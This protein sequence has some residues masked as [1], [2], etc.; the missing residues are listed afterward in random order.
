[1][2]RLSNYDDI[3]DVAD[4]DFSGISLGED[5][6]MLKVH[7]DI[8]FMTKFTKAGKLPAGFESWR[9]SW[10]TQGLAIEN[11]VI[12]EKFRPNWKFVGLRHGQSTAWVILQHPYGFTIEINP[13]A[14]EDIVGSLTM[15]NGVI[16]TPC[17][18]QAKSKN[19]ELLVRKDETH[20]Y[21]LSLVNAVS[22]DV[23][24]VT[25][26]REV[27]EDERPDKVYSVISST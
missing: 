22:D 11:Y 10:R 6:F 14:F 4:G 12:T 2:G 27:I 20:E 9:G 3:I 26:L 7:G 25:R 17:Y 23:D 1:M 21:L 13:S 16:V 19:A 5:D 18:F 8:G 24:L 15:V